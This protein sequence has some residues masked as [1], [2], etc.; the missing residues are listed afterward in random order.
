MLEICKPKLIFCT[1]TTVKKYLLLREKCNFIKRIVVLDTEKDDS[2]ANVEYYDDF[3]NK[4]CGDN[5]K[6]F[7]PINLNENDLAVLLSSSGTTGLPKSV[8]I[9]HRNMSANIVNLR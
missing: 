1:K 6:S 4:Y 3:V 5:F 2:L 9:S 8:M 7:R